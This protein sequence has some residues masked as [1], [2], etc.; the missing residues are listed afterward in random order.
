MQ[1]VK[2]FLI[3]LCPGIE[4][5]HMKNSSPSDKNFNPDMGQNDV[6]S[7][8]ILKYTTQT[9]KPIYKMKSGSNSLIANSQIMIII[10][11][12]LLNYIPSL[13][14]CI[15]NHFNLKMLQFS[16]QITHSSLEKLRKLFCYKNH[17]LKSF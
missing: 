6:F 1:T 9:Q 12:F 2:G 11:S 10:N 16:W 13:G 17:G 8:P 15:P 4:D 5:K 3:P 14:S 7:L